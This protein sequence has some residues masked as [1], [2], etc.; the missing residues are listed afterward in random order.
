[1]KSYNH[2]T[3]FCGGLAIDIEQ[4]DVETGPLCWELLRR[5]GNP[6]HA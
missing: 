2:H 3:V 5:S 6:C 4:M 1:M